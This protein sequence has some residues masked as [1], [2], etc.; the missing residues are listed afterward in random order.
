MDRKRR[1]R[2]DRSSAQIWQQVGNDRQATRT[3]SLKYSRQIPVPEK[4]DGEERRKW[5][6]K[7]LEDRR[8][9]KVHEGNSKNDQNRFPG[10]ESLL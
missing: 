10:F 9:D 6:R 2:T 3:N 5:E 1:R 8:S 4:K 7:F